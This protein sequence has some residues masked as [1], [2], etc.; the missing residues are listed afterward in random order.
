M[1][2]LVD[3]YSEKL[4]LMLKFESTRPPR[5]IHG[6][7]AVTNDI[8]QERRE[9]NTDSD[10]PLAIPMPEPPIPIS[11]EKVIGTDCNTECDVVFGSVTVKSENPNTSE[12]G[13]VQN[14]SDKASGVVIKG[15]S[16]RCVVMEGNSAMVMWGDSNNEEEVNGKNSTNECIQLDCL[17]IEVIRGNGDRCVVRGA[18]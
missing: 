7:T 13:D 10:I 11:M 9:A 6:G 17:S 18:V 3:F 15:N 2:N 5:R 14:A 8:L 1:L 16:D 4:S 12:F